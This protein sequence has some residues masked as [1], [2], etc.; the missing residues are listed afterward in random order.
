MEPT[1][2]NV[3][4]V[5]LEMFANA[6]FQG[7]QLQAANLLVELLGKIGDGSLIVS[8]APTQEVP[9]E[10]MEQGIIEE[11]PAAA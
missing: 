10:M 1:A 8:E 11:A 2:Q 3:A 5:G 7:H 4:K 9:P 6:T